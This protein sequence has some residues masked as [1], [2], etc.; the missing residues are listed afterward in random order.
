M[1][2]WQIDKVNDLYSQLDKLQAE[3]QI[4]KHNAQLTQFNK[5]LEAIEHKIDQ[6]LKSTSSTSRATKTKK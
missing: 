6:M 1:E 5:R 3:N 4:L 2:K